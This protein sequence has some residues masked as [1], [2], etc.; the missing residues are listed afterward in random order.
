MTEQLVQYKYIEDDIDSLLDTAYL[1][2]DKAEELKDKA[3]ELKL[4]KLKLTDKQE[5]ICSEAAADDLGF[6]P[7]IHFSSMTHGTYRFFC[8]PLV[9]GTRKYLKVISTGFVTHKKTGHVLKIVTLLNEYCEVTTCI[10]I[11]Y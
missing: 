2:E 6:L 11:D 8:A 10:D 4:R 5:F 9:G 3:E 1:L 7:C